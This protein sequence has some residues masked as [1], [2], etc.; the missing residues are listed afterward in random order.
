[1]VTGMWVPVDGRVINMAERSLKN[2]NN[3]GL[4]M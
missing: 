2:A 3:T 4:V 1:M